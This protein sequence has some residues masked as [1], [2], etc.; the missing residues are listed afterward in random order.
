MLFRSVPPRVVFLI[1][2]AVVGTGPGQPRHAEAHGA[3]GRMVA[4][5]RVA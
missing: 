3:D 4:E 5:A 2:S 1:L